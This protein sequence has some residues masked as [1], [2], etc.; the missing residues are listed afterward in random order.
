MRYGAEP[1]I[2]LG[3]VHGVYSGFGL[4]PIMH[5]GPTAKGLITEP[6]VADRGLEEA[7]RVAG[8]EL[9][10]TAA[11]V[12][13]NREQPQTVMHALILSSRLSLGG[14]AARLHRDPVELRSTVEALVATTLVVKVDE[15]PVP[16]YAIVGMD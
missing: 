11:S 4:P 2:P 3:E 5:P 7:R 9:L 6:E 1:S 15:E 16:T 8:D 13:E 14:I 12:R 10:A